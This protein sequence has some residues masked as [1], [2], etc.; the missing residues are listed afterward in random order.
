MLLQRARKKMML[1]PCLAIALLGVSA[2]G[3]SACEF[4]EPT[5]VNTSRVELREESFSKV[6]KKG[7]V[8]EGEIKMIAHHYYRYGAGDMNLTVT[9]NPRSKTNTAMEATREGAKI[10]NALRING[11]KNVAVD[12]LPVSGQK[13]SDVLVSYPMMVAQA[14]SGCDD[15]PGWK[16]GPMVDHKETAKYRY[17]CTIEK[18]LAKQISRPRDL[19]GRSGY[20]TSTDGRRQQ[21]V[22]SQGGYYSGTPN[23]PLDGE[24]ASDTE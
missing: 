12:V 8:E 17:G 24:T 1:Y 15:M 3:M 18:Q 5:Q 4:N 10:A 20:T 7:E 14:P 6:Y 23:E 16:D 19:M 22:L 2:I 9:Y 11:V 21:N 13:S